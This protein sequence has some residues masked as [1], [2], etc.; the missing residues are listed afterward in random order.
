MIRDLNDLSRPIHP[1]RFWIMPRDLR[2]TERARTIERIAQNASQRAM[3]SQEVA[4]FARRMAA[5]S[6]A[7]IKRSHR[8]TVP[9]ATN[10]EPLFVSTPEGVAWTID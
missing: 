5:R 9:A 8:G 6:V 4:T 1:T 10:S 7:R 3:A 2:S